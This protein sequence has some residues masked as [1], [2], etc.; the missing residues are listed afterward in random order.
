[1][2][3]GRLDALW[4]TT[5]E[6]LSQT[7]DGARRAIILLSDGDDTAARRS[8]RRPLTWPSEQCR[9]LFN[10]IHDEGSEANLPHALRKVSEKTGGA[11][12]PRTGL[13]LKPPSRKSRRNCARNTS[14][15]ISAATAN[16]TAHS[17]RCESK[18]SIGAAQQKLRLRYREGYYAGTN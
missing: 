18:S 5:N 12:F 6:V 8:G 16:A 4:V 10:G 14:S 7:P 11:F 2:F 15:P 1:M 3:Y 9:H 17:V 13:R